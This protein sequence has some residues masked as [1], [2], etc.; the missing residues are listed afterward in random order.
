MFSVETYDYY[1]TQIRHE[2]DLAARYGPQAVAA[3]G[4]PL[5]VE[6]F[7]AISHLERKAQTALSTV[8]A[9]YA[10]AVL[11]AGFLLRSGLVRWTALALFAVTVG[12]VLL[13]DMAELPGFYRVISLL[14]LALMMA[15]GAWGYQRWLAVRKTNPS[16]DVSHEAL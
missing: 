7:D 16:E 5:D 14:A 2:S 8:W 6:T 4:E 12:K 3:S 11:A 1:H 15:I 9:A 10:A 13:V